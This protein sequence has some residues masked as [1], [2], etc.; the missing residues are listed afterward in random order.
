MTSKQ[1]LNRIAETAR[2]ARDHVFSLATFWKRTVEVDGV[3]L[4]L[5]GASPRMRYVMFRG[6]ESG[7]SSLA[8]RHLTSTDRVLELG[9]SVGFLALRCRKAFPTIAYC[10]VEANPDLSAIIRKNF[11]LN[12]LLMGPL[13][14]VAFGPNDGEVDFGISENFWSSSLLTRATESRRVRIPMLSLSTIVSQM[15]YTP[16][17]LLMDVEGAETS[18]NVTDLKPFSK[19]MIEFHPKLTG[20]H[21]V[22]DII[23]AL[24]KAGFYERDRDSAT[25]YFERKIPEGLGG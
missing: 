5:D 16:N 23:S 17:V 3:K 18:L 9:A 12:G 21:A 24:N 22:R 11:E 6:Y 14:S 1:P 20:E 7:D 10:M 4:T 8:L 19:L 2:A 15:T 13:F 25:R